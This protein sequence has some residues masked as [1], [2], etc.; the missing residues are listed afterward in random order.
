VPTQLLGLL[1]LCLLGSVCDIMKMQSPTSPSK[2]Q[3]DMVTITS[4]A[5]ENVNNWFSA[6]N[7]S[8][9]SLDFISLVSLQSQKTFYLFKVSPHPSTPLVLSS[10][11]HQPGHLHAAPWG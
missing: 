7:R 2:S 3:G 8:Q 11:L 1:L 5:S 10:Q 4:R 6:V 9:G